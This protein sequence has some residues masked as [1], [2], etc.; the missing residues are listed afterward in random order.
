MPLWGFLADDVANRAAQPN[1]HAAQT[2]MSNDTHNHWGKVPAVVSKC[3]FKLWWPL[4]AV[5]GS[6]FL[7]RFCNTTPPLLLPPPPSSLSRSRFARSWATTGA[8]ADG[9]NCSTQRARVRVPP[10]TRGTHPHAR[11]HV[12]KHKRDNTRPRTALTHAA[13]NK[14][15]V[16]GKKQQQQSSSAAWYTISIYMKH[17]GAYRTPA[18]ADP[19]TRVRVSCMRRVSCLAGVERCEVCRRMH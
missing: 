16:G 10:Q 3:L 4:A 6:L 14:Q 5:P 9:E 18:R 17:P 15:A 13:R 12:R 19:C 1:H 2:S 7:P 8:G 11:G